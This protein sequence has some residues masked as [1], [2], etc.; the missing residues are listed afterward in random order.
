MAI[1]Y[2]G[3]GAQVETASGTTSVLPYPAGLAAGHLLMIVGST[4][5]ATTLWT[6]PAGWTQVYN[7][8][9]SGG[10]LTPNLFVAYKVAAGSESGSLT[11]THS[12][13]V[14]IARMFA[15]SGVNAGTPLDVPVAVN[16]AA[17]AATTS[18]LPGL[19]TTAPGAALVYAAAHVS[20]TATAT[21]S[22][23]PSAYTEVMDRATGSRA[24][25]AGYLIWS[26]SGATGSPVVT[27]TGSGRSMGLLLALRPSAA[28]ATGIYLSA[29]A[30]DTAVV[31]GTET[32]RLASLS[33]ATGAAT[34]AVRAG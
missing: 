23:T 8:S 26:G 2:V 1:A 31:I 25:T 14:S 3:A 29:A 5:N 33:T 34:Q 28:P 4:F 6:L 32:K 16:D 13:N 17:G 12:S 10:T 11:V 7:A 22:A 27:W 30:A 19:T 20:T 24:A 9:A 18:T 21:V 15:F